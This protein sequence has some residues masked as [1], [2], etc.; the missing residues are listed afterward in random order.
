M[1]LTEEA[2]GAARDGGGDG[3]G[4]RVAGNSARGSERREDVRGGV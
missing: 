1:I 4:P 2:D 3:T